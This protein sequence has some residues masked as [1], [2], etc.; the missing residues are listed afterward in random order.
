M[1]LD[2]NLNEAAPT[3]MASPRF[4]QTMSERCE[5]ALA[6]IDSRSPH[7]RTM[8]EQRLDQVCRSILEQVQATLIH[9][10]RVRM[11]VYLPLIIVLDGRAAAGKS[12]ISAA[13]SELLDLPLFHMDDFYLPPELRVD[14]R[15]AEAGGNVDYQRFRDDVLLPLRRGE[16]FTYQKL[17]PHEWTFSEPIQINSTDMVIVEGAYAL[18][19]LLR[20]FY[21]SDLSFFIDV[22]PDEQAERLYERNGREAAEAFFERWIP[23]EEKYIAVMKPE[24]YAIRTHKL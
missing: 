7:T 18:H 20:D 21:R 14:S 1:D 4:F 23:F 2:H 6:L 11:I 10:S 15:F 8:D 5:Q 24:D 9:L 13:L 17:V 22:D 19:E 3:V 12:T 16:A